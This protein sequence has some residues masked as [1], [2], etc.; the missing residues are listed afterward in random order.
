[1][2]RDI[3]FT[4]TEESAKEIYKATGGSGFISGDILW[5]RADGKVFKLLKGK[6]VSVK[7]P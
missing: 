7:C 2:S 1:M 5:L 6:S 4:G 3:T